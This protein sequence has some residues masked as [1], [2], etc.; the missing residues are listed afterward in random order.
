MGKGDV[1]DV[2]DL[3]LTNT[4]NLV[5]AILLLSLK[6]QVILAPELGEK[7]EN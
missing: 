2:V 1:G 5:K 6:S 3:G 4:L 7:K